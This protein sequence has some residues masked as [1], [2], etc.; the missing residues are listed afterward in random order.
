[1]SSCIKPESVMSGCVIIKYVTPFQL[2]KSLDSCKKRFPVISN[3][4]GLSRNK[5]LGFVWTIK[6]SCSVEGVL[7]WTVVHCGVLRNKGE[8]PFKKGGTANAE[9]ESSLG[10]ALGHPPCPQNNFEI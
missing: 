9:G 4:F 6:Q 1:M 5:R 3:D 7:L 2:S 10:A 8:N